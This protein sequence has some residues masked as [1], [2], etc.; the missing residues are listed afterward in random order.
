VFA[1]DLLLGPLGEERPDVQRVLRT[2]AQAQAV[3]GQPRAI[4]AITW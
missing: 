3:D 1:E 2:Q 4:S